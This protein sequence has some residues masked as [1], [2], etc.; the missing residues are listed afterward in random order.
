MLHA[1]QLTPVVER[2]LKGLITFLGKDA[3]ESSGNDSLVKLYDGLKSERGNKQI[4]AALEMHQAELEDF[5]KSIRDLVRQRGDE[6][7]GRRNAALVQLRFISWMETLS[8]RNEGLIFDADI[9]AQISEELGR[10]QVRA[11]ELI[12]RSL[13]TERFGDQQKLEQELSQLFSDKVVGKWKKG[14]DQGDLLSGTTFSELAGLFVNV[15]EYPNYA[16]LYEETPFLTYLRDKRKTIQ[17]FLDDIRR[18]RNT[19]A[20]NKQVS[21]TQLSLLDLYYE[22]LISP[23]QDAHDQGQTKVNPDTF[24]D[25]S[26]DELDDYFNNLHEDI[27]SVKDDIASMRESLQGTLGDIAADTGEIRKGTKNIA[28][29]VAAAVVGIAVVIWLV[30]SGKEEASEIRESTG[31]MEQEM[32]RSSAAIEQIA[33]SS[34]EISVTLLSMQ[35]SFSSLSKRGG[36]IDQAQRPEELYHNARIYELRGD[37]L[38]ARKSYEQ[39]FAF[40]LDV[41]DPYLRYQRILKAQEGVAGATR[42]FG[43]VK[44]KVPGAAYAS[45]RAVLLNDQQR[46]VALQQVTKE[47]SSFA[48][49]FYLLSREFSQKQLGQQSLSNKRDEKKALEQF[50]QLAKTG[51]FL[52]YFI[53]KEMAAQWLDDAKTRLKPLSVVEKE[54]TR[55]PF[56]YTASRSNSGWNIYFNIPEAVSRFAYKVEGDADFKD[57]GLQDWIDQRSGKQTAKTNFDLPPNQQDTVLYIKYADIHGKENGP[58]R[59]EFNVMEELVRSQKKTLNITKNSWLAFGRNHNS[60]YLYFSHVQSYR[61][62]IAEVK[63]GLGK[64]TPDT[65]WDGLGDCNTDDPVRVN[66]VLK[67]FRPVSADIRFVTVQLKFKDGT[68]SEVVK[69]DRR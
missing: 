58:Y 15:Q 44:P 39:F 51:D 43:M 7:A 55:P 6:E 10:K 52:K 34:A 26:K 13:I 65:I 9:P 30:Y 57:T 11:L 3:E 63:Y 17:N 22:E 69:I 49:A 53:D 48:P 64:M 16:P 2:L 24:L 35:Q 61:C 12:L 5:N 56:I 45:A 41:I 37:F 25:I 68:Q 47:T 4:A 27:Q 1:D 54:P 66:A 29:G 18:V 28:I 42:A 21:N 33:E 59:V 14:A 19:L 60:K 46:T 8:S 23:V 32:E 20:H 40:G 67:L 50:L 62:A 36:I 31:R 38:N